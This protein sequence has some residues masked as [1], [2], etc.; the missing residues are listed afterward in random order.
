MQFF[1]PA[2]KDDAARDH[3]YGAIKSHLSY[4]AEN[5]FADRKIQFL[6][7]VHNGR[8]VEAEVGKTHPMNGEPVVAI[9]Y[10]PGRKLYHVC[11]TNRGVARGDAILAGE[12]SVVDERDFD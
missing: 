5:R 6:R 9:L 4:G 2:A 3:V 8:D 7:Y 1:I 12:T 11:T 10:E